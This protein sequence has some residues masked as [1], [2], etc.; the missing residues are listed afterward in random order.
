M[1]FS[2]ILTLYTYTSWDLTWWIFAA[3]LYSALVSWS[4]LYCGLHSFTDLAGGLIV[5]VATCFIWY[6][7]DAVLEIWTKSLP[8]PI[9]SSLAFTYALILIHPHPSSPCPCF[10]DSIS[11][12]AVLCGVFVAAQMSLNDVDID[13]QGPRNVVCGI[14][15]IVVGVTLLLSWRTFTKRI[16]ANILPAIFGIRDT[17]KNHQK[18]SDD[19]A[20]DEASRVLQ[21]KKVDSF[22]II[23]D[24]N[25]SHP[26]LNTLS[27]YNHDHH[28]RKWLPNEYK[29][30]KWSLL[31]LGKV[32]CYGGIG[33]IAIHGALLVF[34][35]LGI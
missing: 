16:F 7:L 35:V 8:A 4:R 14:L 11:F 32:V 19:K 23:N 15:R 21:L 34:G 26:A 29:L 1:A 2:F 31:T 27:N 13:A 22:A 9:L 20:D 18:K 3:V 24:P 28:R 33:F 10:E 17:P 30:D 12:A 6:L 25:G 5:A